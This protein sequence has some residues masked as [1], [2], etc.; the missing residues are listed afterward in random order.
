MKFLLIG[1]GILATT[2]ALAQGGPDGTGRSGVVLA[3]AQTA[4]NLTFTT[5]PNV[6]RENNQRLI[7]SLGQGSTPAEQSELRRRIDTN[8]FFN[9]FAAM[10]AAGG[11]S[12]N[13]LPDVVTGYLVISWE[14][15]TGGDARPYANGFR[16]LRDKV[17]ALM[18][19]DS[20]ITRAS[21]AERQKTAETL[22]ITAMASALSRN[23]LRQQGKAAELAKLQAAV[24]Q[25][26][27]A[28]QGVD[29]AT[30]NFT[31]DG[32]VPR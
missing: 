4:P 10:L 11:Y 2:P 1:I 5:A 6:R 29:L 27:M 12:P 17:A 14:V 23:S 9:D 22:T 26:V 8:I 24:R 7:T 32:F 13:S 20:K 21:S 3:Q 30:V 18:A 15:V 28:Q 16:I 19:Q 25:A 31:N